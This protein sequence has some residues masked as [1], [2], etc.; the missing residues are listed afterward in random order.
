VTEGSEPDTTPTYRPSSESVYQCKVPGVVDDEEHCNKFW[1]CKE[2]SEGSGI[3][4]SLLYRCPDGYLFSNSIL[5][6]KK[7]EDITCVNKIESRNIFT[8]QLTEDM[9]DSFFAEWTV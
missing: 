2:E 7:E 3:L 5:R 9:L 6:C 4:Q 1:L 8:L